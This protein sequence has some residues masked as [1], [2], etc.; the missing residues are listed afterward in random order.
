MQLIQSGENKILGK[1]FFGFVSIIWCIGTVLS[2][3]QYPGNN[4]YF[5]IFCVATFLMFVVSRI[6]PISYAYLFLCI[7]WTLGFWVKIVLYYA[8][9]YPLLEPIGLFDDSPA[10]WDKMLNIASIAMFAFLICRLFFIYYEKFDIVHYLTNIKVDIPEWYKNNS[11]F[12]WFLALFILLLLSAINLKY[13]FYRIGFIPVFQPPLKLGALFPWFLNLGIVSILATFIWW[14]IF[15]KKELSLKIVLLIFSSLV[16]AVSILSRGIFLYQIWHYFFSAFDLQKR[17]RL[18]K[19][20]IVLFSVIFL[21]GMF[22]VVRITMMEREYFYPIIH[23]NNKTNDTLISQFLRAGDLDN[24]FVENNAVNRHKKSKAKN[25]FIRLSAGR[26]IGVEGL[27]AVSSWPQLG[28]DLFYR[29]WSTRLAPGAHHPFMKISD[30]MYDKPDYPGKDKFFFASLPGV[31]AMLYYSGSGLVVFFGIF[32]LYLIIFYSE[33]FITK[34]L[35]NP[36]IVSFYGIYTAVLV[37]ML[38]DGRSFFIQLIELWGGF[39]LL[40]LLINIQF[41]VR[42]YK[43]SKLMILEK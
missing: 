39:V 9:D 12:L 33:I 20:L 28:K 14:D 34:I 16:V 42:A 29:G 24:S 17:I 36:F 43:P 3:K 30:S 27:M 19:Y 38:A 6:R 18:K 13:N 41:I 15:L 11:R 25:I 10:E 2:L 7:F 23:F 5:F 21:V 32:L 4:Y 1:I 22:F 31:V 37:S 26:W 35:A 40:W 8:L